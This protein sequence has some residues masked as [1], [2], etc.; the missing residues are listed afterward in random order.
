MRGFFIDPAP[1]MLFRGGG[2][3]A[4][5]A[6]D[7]DDDRHNDVISGAEGI[8]QSAQALGA[9]DDD[10]S[11]PSDRGRAAGDIA[12]A[13]AVAEG[14]GGGNRLTPS[15]ERRVTQSPVQAKPPERE[16]IRR[17]V[18]VLGIPGSLANRANTLF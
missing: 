9:G 16:R 14:R 2:E 13:A 17:A 7:D 6:G 18:I 11:G 1:P 3:G 4:S 5:S 12:E 15:N 8:D 10:L